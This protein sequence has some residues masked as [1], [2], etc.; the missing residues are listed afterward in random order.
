MISDELGLSFMRHGVTGWALSV[1][2][3]MVFGAGWCWMVRVCCVF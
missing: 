1:G 2:A 3:C